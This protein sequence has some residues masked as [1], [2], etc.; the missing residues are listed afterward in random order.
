MKKL[1]LMISLASA[2]AF[3]NAQDMTSKKGTP[4]LPEAG[5]WSIGFNAVPVLNYFGNLANGDNDNSASIDWADPIGM[6]IMIKMMKDESTAYRGKIRL[7]INSG[8]NET[9]VGSTTTANAQVLNKTEWSSMNIGIGAGIQKYRGKGRL[10]GYYGAELGISLGSGPDSTYTY[11]NALDSTLNPGPRTKEYN[12]G[13]TFGI[14]LRGFIGV[15]YFF[16]PKMSVS[17]EYGWG[18]ALSSRGEGETISEQAV[19]TPSPGKT[20][21]TSKFGIDTDN[22]SGSILLSFYF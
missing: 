4:I 15:E 17:A 10:K 5:D 3:A 20:G 2:V 12:V 19:G 21:G 16:A 6:T 9:Y 22:A 13:S 14:D 11:G 7:G 8:S 1:F 18:L